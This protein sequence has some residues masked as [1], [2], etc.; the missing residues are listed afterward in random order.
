MRLKDRKSELKVGDMPVVEGHLGVQFRRFVL[1]QF[2]KKIDL[3]LEVCCLDD[4]RVVAPAGTQFV[5][6]EIESAW[7]L[8]H[9]VDLDSTCNVFLANRFWLNHTDVRAD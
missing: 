6:E 9:R 8:S 1:P 2:Q 5:V 7:E 4:I 3:L